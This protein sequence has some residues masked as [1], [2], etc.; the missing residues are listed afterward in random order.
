VTR[1]PVLE[2]AEEAD[3]VRVGDNETL[4]RIFHRISVSWGRQ[5]A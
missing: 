5:M 3:S 1:V 2:Q 4:A